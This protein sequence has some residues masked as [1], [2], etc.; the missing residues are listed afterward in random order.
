MKFD[1]PPLKSDHLALCSDLKHTK[2]KLKT[3]RFDI[4][5]MMFAKSELVPAWFDQNDAKSKLQAEKFDC[6]WKTD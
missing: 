1:H 4:F 3:S 5:A 2:F 6:S